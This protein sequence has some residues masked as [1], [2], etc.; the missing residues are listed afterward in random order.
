MTIKVGEAIGAAHWASYLINGDESGLEP[1]EKALADKWQESLAPAYAVDVKRD[2]D[3]N[4]EDS[5]FTWG[6]WLHVRL[7]SPLG[8]SCLTYVTHSPDGDS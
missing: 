1:D 5:W 7:E 2:Y 6:Y 4:G 3:G 8:G